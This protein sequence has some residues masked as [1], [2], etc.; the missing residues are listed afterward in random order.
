MTTQTSFSDRV[1]RIQARAEGR[2][3]KAQ[4]I[5]PMVGEDLREIERQKG[6]R[7]RSARAAMLPL[8]I[9]GVTAGL[10][11]GEIITMLPPEVAADMLTRPGTLGE[12]MR[13]QVTPE[14][15]AMLT[16]IQPDQVATN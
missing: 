2:M 15:L 10:F 8:M 3:P 1:A 4:L 9:A 7:G 14:Q 11:S 16:A 12:L 6:R 13:A 5:A